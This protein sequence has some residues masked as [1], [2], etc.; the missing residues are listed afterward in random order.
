M[1]HCFINYNTTTRDGSTV[2]T[3]QF[4]ISAGTEQDIRN[5]AQVISELLER[6][7]IKHSCKFVYEPAIV[8]L[9]GDEEDED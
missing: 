7:Q 8:D 1:F 5:M 3:E 4:H 9:E 6:L 2:I